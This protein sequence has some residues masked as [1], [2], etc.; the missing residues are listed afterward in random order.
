[1]INNPSHHKYR[2]WC[3]PQISIFATYRSVD[4]NS[5]CVLLQ[6][7]L[8][9]DLLLH[10]VANTRS[11]KSC[12]TKLNPSHSMQCSWINACLCLCASSEELLMSTR[13]V[14]TP[15]NY[16]I[17]INSSA[18]HFQ[19]YKEK[20]GGSANVFNININANGRANQQGTFL[21]NGHFCFPLFTRKTAELKRKSVKQQILR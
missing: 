11:N 20:L 10:K 13:H 17:A 21:K 4:A 19:T 9:H 7:C 8:N 14:F 1:M 5:K 15:Q 6:A 18:C 2:V 16:H 3:F 12:L